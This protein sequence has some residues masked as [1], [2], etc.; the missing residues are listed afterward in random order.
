LN[1]LIGV[2]VFVAV[3]AFVIISAILTGVTLGIFLVCLIP[4]MCLLIPVM[5]V[6]Y[7]VVEQANVALVVENL[8]ITK[9]ISRGWQV[10]RD[11]LGSMFVMSLIL[12]LVVGFI[13]GAVI[14]LPLLIVSAPIFIGYANGTAQAIWNGWIISGLFFLLYLPF[15]LLLSGVIRSYT[16]SAWTLTFMQATAKPAQTLIPAPDLPQEMGAPSEPSV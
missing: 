6:V 16:A 8:G 4:L 3:I 15:L 5:W 13:G 9:A 11:N 14:G 10:V 1:L 2:I 12:I 7:V